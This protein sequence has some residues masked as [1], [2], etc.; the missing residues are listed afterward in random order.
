MPTL[1]R[2]PIPILV[3]HQIA[4]APPKGSSPFRGLYVAPAAFARQMAWLKRL[5]YTGLSMGGLMPYLR[6]ER[7]GKVV[8]ITFDDGYRNNLSHA[9][10]VLVKHGFSST[11]YAVSGLLGKTNIWDQNIGIP[12]TP[13]M[14]EG[15][16]RQWVAGGQEIGSHTRSHAN[17]LETDEAGCVEEMVQGKSGLE[18]V[19]GS[20]VAHFCYPFGH[21]NAGHVEMARTL[22]FATA[23]TTQRSRCHEGMDLL[24]LPRVPVL[25]T[26]SLPVFWLK[27]A[28]AYEDRRKK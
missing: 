24:Q 2:Q 3:Y 22:G 9:L 15:E 16:I 5:G 27:V 20:P 21:F 25:R 7:S 23:T 12:Q 19:T 28:T 14:D 10:P 6:G 26:T 11:C 17:L 8:G 18:A 4:E 1:N 13:L